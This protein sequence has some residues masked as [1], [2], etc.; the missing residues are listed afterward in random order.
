MKVVTGKY[1]EARGYL[2]YVAAL[3]YPG[4][5]VPV[6]Q[7]P[8]RIQTDLQ[9]CSDDDFTLLLEEGRRQLE[10]QAADMQ[11]NH[12]RAATLLTVTVAELV[13][14]AASGPGVFSDGLLVIAIWLVSVTLSVLALAGTVSVLTSSAE[15]GNVSTV[16]LADGPRPV[17]PELARQ[18]TDAVGTGEST[19]AARLTI[20][21]D[22]VWL[23]VIAAVFLVLTTPFTSK[24]STT[25]TCAVSAG[26]RCVIDGPTT[27]TG[28]A[29][30]SQ[31]QVPAPTASSTSATQ[32]GM[33]TATSGNLSGPRP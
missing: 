11:R 25:T 32:T 18:Y 15:Y 4:R 19:N 28:S 16:D 33:G 1:A 22:A 23:A 24:P 3:L 29:P 5:E 14:L 31:T 9:D 27:R 12:T 20:L 26:A 6:F 2:Q 10:R 8:R 21:R 30:P 17:L 7:Q 13:F